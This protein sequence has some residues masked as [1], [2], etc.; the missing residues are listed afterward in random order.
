MT[1]AEA[2]AVVVISVAA[3]VMEAGGAPDVARGKQI[4]ARAGR[5]SADGGSCGR[6]G[7]RS[8]RGGGGRWG[9]S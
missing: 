2:E 7:E 5:R 6:S 1:E 8:R 4:L 3:A 9:G